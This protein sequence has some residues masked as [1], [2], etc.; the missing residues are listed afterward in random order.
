MNSFRES[1]ID[2]KNCWEVKGCGR[3]PGGD[4][5][6]Q[7]GI[8]PAALEKRLDGKNNGVNAGRSCWVVAGTL[9]DQQTHDDFVN[10]IAR[11]K[12]CFFYQQ[13]YQEEGDNIVPLMDLFDCIMDLEAD[14]R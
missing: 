1:M 3:H 5:I 9:C 13:V 12:K 6:D 4:N 14:I 11:C 2:K 7:R 8:C 10:K